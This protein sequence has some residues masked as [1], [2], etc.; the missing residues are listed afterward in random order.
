MGCVVVLLFF[1]I[2]QR[3]F[4]SFGVAYPFAFL[5]VGALVASAFVPSFSAFGIR[6][7]VSGFVAPLL[8]SV[9]FFALSAKTREGAH[10]AVS[11]C[12]VFA[13]YVAIR[14]LLSPV[15]NA[16]TVSVCGG[17]LCAATA[18]FVG[19][20]KLAAVAGVFGGIPF[21]VAVSAAV[22]KISYGADIVLGSPS[23][24]DATVIAAVF[25]VVLCEVVAAVRKNVNGKRAAAA[26]AAE[27][28]DPDEYKKYFDE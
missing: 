20:T 24:F 5:I 1:G 25:A 18:Y 3:V 21:G 7:S 16:A 19:K 2:A 23:V 8:L 4:K 11:A 14:L 12:A 17:L 26:E 22:E 13:V 6:V 28:F 10:A 9:L 15:S 27:E